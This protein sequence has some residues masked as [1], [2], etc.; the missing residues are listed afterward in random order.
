M[1]KLAAFPL[2]LFFLLA[3]APA[4][5][6]QLVSTGN[7]Q[8]IQFLSP[9][10]VNLLTQAP[11]NP[12]LLTGTGTNEFILATQG[13]P[14]SVANVFITNDTANPCNNLT[15]SFGTT[16]ANISSFNSFPT[17]WQPLGFLP[18]QATAAGFVSSSGAITLPANAT[19]KI[20]TLPIAARS[21]LIQLPLSSACPTT[22]IDVNI[23]FSNPINLTGPSS[24][25]IGQASVSPFAVV[26]DV[27]GQSYATSILTASPAVSTEL[28][29]LHNAAATSKSIYFDR[30]VISTSSTTPV[31]V[32][33]QLTNGLGTGCSTGTVSASNGAKINASVP[34]IATQVAPACTSPPGG[35]AFIS[36]TLVV[37]NS[38]PFVLDLKG[39][40]APAN[41]T[42]GIDV[43]NTANAITGA[44]DV[45]FYWNEL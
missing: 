3:V 32:T 28:G 24:P 8:V 31:Q 43:I 2:L 35:L 23:F 14:N 17:F 10:S 42:T 45:D 44:L 16:G 5:L 36:R 38:A 19:V 20:T 6:A 9:P 4:T 30:V 34:S 18:T 13:L 22:T 29:G 7:E 33:V 25:K 26:S 1:K 12:N 15:I 39:F 21:L 11:V 27:F 37:S 40:I 41:S